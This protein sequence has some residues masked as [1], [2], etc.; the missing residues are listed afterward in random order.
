MLAQPDAI[1][2]IRRP[3][4]NAS[5]ITIVI[6]PPHA[7]NEGMTQNLLPNKTNTI[8]TAR[9]FRI[10]VL[11]QRGALLRSPL[12][13]RTLK[14]GVKPDVDGG[15]GCPCDDVEFCKGQRRGCLGERQL[16]T[17]ITR[18]GGH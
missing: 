17:S 10:R 12:R 8:S 3:H 2:C 16:Q 4:F 13:N 15:V 9:I 7:G 6:T 5:Y 18:S 14:G 11:I 1:V